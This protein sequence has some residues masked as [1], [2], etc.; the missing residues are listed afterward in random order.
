MVH[1]TTTDMTRNPKQILL[2]QTMQGHGLWHIFLVH[3]NQILQ[4]ACWNKNFEDAVM[5]EAHV[6]R[7]F[8]RTP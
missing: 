7:P 5:L 3:Q 8:R 2:Q 1:K 6:R 4:K